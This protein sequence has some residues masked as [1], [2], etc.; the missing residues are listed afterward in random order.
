MF[1]HDL[2]HAAKGRL[3]LYDRCRRAVHKARR[4]IKSRYHKRCRH[5]DRHRAPEDF[6]A[7]QTLTC[8]IGLDLLRLHTEHFQIRT[9]AVTLQTVPALILTAQLSEQIIQFPI[10][11]HAVTIGCPDAAGSPGILFIL[12]RPYAQ[13]RRKSCRRSH[14]KRQKDNQRTDLIF[15]RML[16]Y[17]G[18]FLFSAHTQY[19]LSS[20]GFLPSPLPPLILIALTQKC[21]YKIPI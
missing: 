17:Y 7:G 10:L 19:P 6:F 1:L 20:G 9:H 16:P 13:K 15:L 8:S 2:L 18:I 5:R 11:L 3:R 4:Y 12:R 14:K 21:C